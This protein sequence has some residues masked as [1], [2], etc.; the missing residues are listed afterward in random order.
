MVKKSTIKD[1]I[2]R[3]PDAEWTA[4]NSGRSWT[5]QY[6]RDFKIILSETGNNDELFAQLLQLKNPNSPHG[7]HPGWL[8]GTFQFDKPAG[9][10]WR[11]KAFRQTLHWAESRLKELE[12]YYKDAH[13]A[14]IDALLK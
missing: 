11:Q 4:A 8:T 7:C 9:S 14:V 3:Y 10:D 6:C 13:Q 2:P 1:L 12:A 5:L